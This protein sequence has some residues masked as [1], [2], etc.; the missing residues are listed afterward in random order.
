VCQKQEIF[1]R[2]CAGRYYHRG[3]CQS[4]KKV[5]V[6]VYASLTQALTTLFTPEATR[7]SSETLHSDPNYLKLLHPR[8]SL[9]STFRTTL[10]TLHCLYY[11]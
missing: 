5:S 7:W 1:N 11:T 6:T 9:P 2:Q 3:I 8:L 4:I 10:Y